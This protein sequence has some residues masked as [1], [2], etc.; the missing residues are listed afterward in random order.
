MC[1]LWGEGCILELSM[2]FAQFFCELK[3][4]ALASVAQLEHCPVN[5]K[6]A[7]SVPSQGT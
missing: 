1:V 5:W 7:G 3:S 2:L 6:V 4:P